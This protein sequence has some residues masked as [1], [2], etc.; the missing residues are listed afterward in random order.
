MKIGVIRHKFRRL[1]SN[2]NIMPWRQQWTC[3]V[4][5]GR[6]DNSTMDEI[7]INGRNCFYANSNN[8]IT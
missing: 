1:G 3:I 5:T 7:Q 2:N 4:A 6:G 8:N